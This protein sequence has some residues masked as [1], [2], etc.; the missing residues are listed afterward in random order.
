MTDPEF[1]W[2]ALAVLS[3]VLNAMF[4]W[5]RVT[6]KSEAREIG[7]QP[8]KVQ[9]VEEFVTS[10]HPRLLRIDERLDEMKSR[11]SAMEELQRESYNK[12]MESAAAARL[13]LHEKIDKLGE[14][15][16]HIEGTIEPLKGVTERIARDIGR[17]EGVL[18]RQH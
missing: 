15:V 18:Q 5:R 9:G 13:R 11:V 6:G 10:K 12:L 16:A 7:P 3:S 8:L 4:L 17:L 14:T 2:K 1:L